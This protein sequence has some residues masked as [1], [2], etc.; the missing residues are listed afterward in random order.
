MGQ[1]CPVTNQTG[2]N[3]GRFLFEVNRRFEQ[4]NGEDKAMFDG[5]SQ[6]VI[7]IQGIALNVVH[8]GNGPPI[9]LLHGYPQTHV[10]WHKLASALADPDSG[11]KLS[12]S[13]ARQVPV[14][15]TPHNTSSDMTSTP[16]RVHI[17]R[18]R[19]P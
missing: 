18:T 9:L 15:P 13:E 7:D 3:Y 2:E 11:T 10:M 4:W 1:V 5:F 14:R 8:G 17:S 16:Y 19:S 6:V 12:C